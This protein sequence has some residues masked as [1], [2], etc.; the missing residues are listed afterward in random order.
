MRKTLQRGRDKFAQLFLDE[1]ARFQ[2]NPTAD[3]LE[4]DLV[5][6]DMLELCRS[7]LQEW[8]EDVLT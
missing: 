5:E 7:A 2:E 4:K 1:L 3:D 6:L 8:S